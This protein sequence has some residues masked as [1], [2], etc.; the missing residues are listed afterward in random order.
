MYF[1][2]TK[3]VNMVIFIAL[4]IFWGGGGKQGSQ[5]Q[6]GGGRL[7]GGVNNMSSLLIIFCLVLYGTQWLISLCPGL[8]TE[9]HLRALFLGKTCIALT[10]LW[11]VIK[12]LT[13]VLALTGR[14]KPWPFFHLWRKLASFM[15]NV[16]SRRKISF[17][18]YPDQSDRPNW[19]PD[20]YTNAKKVDRKTWSSISCHFTWLLHG[21]NCPS[22]G[23]FIRVF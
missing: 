20:M 12:V 17:H 8:Q 3:L 22:Q 23:C 2:N 13:P 10:H 16:C 21:K 5:W 18:W 7:G 9:C 19:A 15:L 6:W 11:V 1:L 4:W 14:G